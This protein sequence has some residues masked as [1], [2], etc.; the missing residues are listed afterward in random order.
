MPYEAHSR[1]VASGVV[2]DTTGGT[3]M[4]EWS[5]SV[6][7]T[8]VGGSA[9]VNPAQRAAIVTAVHSFHAS[10][11]ASISTVCKLRS[12]KINDFGPAGAVLHQTN[13]PTNDVTGNLGG[14]SGSAPNWPLQCAVAVSLDTGL[15]GG[16]RRG[17]FYLPPM[18]GPDTFFTGQYR[19]LDSVR[20]GLATAVK[21][22][23]DECK[24]G[25]AQAIVASSLVGNTPVKTV[26]VGNV[27]DTLR[28][29]R[30]HLLEA[31]SPDAVLS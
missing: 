5:W 12:V 15:R 27:I 17:R 8:Q 18:S 26:R 14:I 19:L 9:Y 21:N 11:G 4:E 30:N 1:M 23:L 7:F 22:M 2:L 25:G 10:A 6:A 24:T 3:V 13:D 31:Y 20:D 29:R 16:R 28:T